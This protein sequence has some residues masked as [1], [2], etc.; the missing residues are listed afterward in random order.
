MP[1]PTPREGEEQD[2]F[3]SRCMG[4]ETANADF[5]DQE[6]RAAVCHRQ[7]REAHGEQA[8]DGTTAACWSNHLGIWAIEPL[9]FQQQVALF[10]A[11]HLPLWAAHQTLEARERRTYALEEHTALIPIAGPMTKGDSKFGGTSTIRTRHAL[12]QAARDPEVSSIVLQVYSPGGHVDGVQD[13]A[14]EVW[15]VRQMKPVVAHIE[16]LGASAAYWVASQAGRIT[17]N[18]TA[19]IGSIGTMA[20]L[21]DSSKRLE[22]LGITVHVVATG[23]YKGLGVDG[24]PVSAEALGYVRARVEAINQHFLA[25]IERGRNLRGDALAL[26]SDG[27]VHHAG[28][29]R[30]L[31]LLDAVQSLDATLEELRRGRVVAAPS[32]SSAVPGRNHAA[33]A[34]LALVEQ[35]S[36]Q[37]CR[38]LARGETTL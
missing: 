32:L 33:W 1:L 5:P 34:R 3:I 7:W 37:Q 26:V 13:L 8:A 36:R 35:Q 10:Q 28:P 24:A 2:E 17:A 4:D 18:A 19:E 25:S 11:G 6:Q 20:V 31:G 23:P 30:R 15:R 16:D 21:E 22:R 9:W 29:A 12:R 27:R 38:A 14:D